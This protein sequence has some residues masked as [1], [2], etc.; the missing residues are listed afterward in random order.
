[1]S[2]T[3]FDR[4][5][6]DAGGPAMI[7]ALLGWRDF[8]APQRAA[9]ALEAANDNDEIRLDNTMDTGGTAER[10]IKR[11]KAGDYWRP[12]EERFDRPRRNEPAKAIPA[13]MAARNG[14]AYHQTELDAEDE[15]IRIIDA[16]KART[17]LGH[18]CARLLDLASEGAPEAET[19]KAVKQPGDGRISKWID[20]AT[21]RWI[22]DDAY[23]DYAA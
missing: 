4:L 18:V 7:V 13:N 14:E 16:A 19:A 23:A 6:R 8:Q 5:A 2:E 21:I 3:T 15:A 17:R 11:H 9:L 10:A 22:R 20:H 12:D 1:M